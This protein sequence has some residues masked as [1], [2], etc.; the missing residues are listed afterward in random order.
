M[1]ELEPEEELAVLDMYAKLVDARIKQLR[2][3][4]P[5]LMR[6]Q[7]VKLRAVE[8][9]DGTEVANIRYSPGNVTAKITDEA[10]AV[11]WCGTVHPGEVEEVVTIRPA[12]RKLLLEYSA[13]SGHPGEAGVDPR[14]GERLDFIVVERGTP[15]VKVEPTEQ[16]R[17]RVR[18]LAGGSPREILS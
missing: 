4:L 11:R 17:E 7:R 8:A 3:A 9:A 10:A 12:F 5:E 13:K 18:A 2:A 15:Y 1:T 14:T 16:G 6:Q